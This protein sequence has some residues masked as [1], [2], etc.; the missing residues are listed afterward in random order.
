MDV[1]LSGMFKLVQSAGRRM[2]E[3]RQG[4]IVTITPFDG[5]G[6]HAGR[7]NYTA[8]KHGVIGMTRSVAIEWARLGTRVLE[9]AAGGRPVG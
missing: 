2:A 8:S 5:L 3:R 1:N 4:A 7:A 6:G 9:D